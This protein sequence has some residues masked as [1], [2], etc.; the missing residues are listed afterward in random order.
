MHVYS[1]TN[2][3]P[4]S[5]TCRPI[6][7]MPISAQTGV[8]CQPCNAAHALAVLPA[9]QCR[10]VHPGVGLDRG[11]DEVQHAQGSSVRVGSTNGLA[12]FDA[13]LCASCQQGVTASRRGGC[14]R[15]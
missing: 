6:S 7:P 4:Y 8:F 10:Y 9:T 15:Q 1:E 2:S 3:A 5:V 13:L 12:C 14:K 11:Q